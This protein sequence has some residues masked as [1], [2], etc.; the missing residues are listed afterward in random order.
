MAFPPP[1]LADET[2]LLAVGGD[3]SPRRLL[4]AYSLGIFPWYSE[5]LPI[6]WHS[7]DPR[8]VLEAD[9]I[10]L[11]R[12]L[13]KELRRGRYQV[14]LDTAFEEVIR[15]CAEMPRPGQSGTWITEEMIE[16]YLEM[17]E[18]GYAHSAE[19]WLGDRLVGG[20]YGVSLGAG[21]FGESMFARATDASKVAFASLV[22]QL[23]RWDIRLIDCQVHTEHMARFGAEEWPRDRF[24]RA[25]A[26]ALEQPTRRGR[27]R[28][29]EDLTGPDAEKRD[30]PFG[31]P[32]RKPPSKPTGG[33]CGGPR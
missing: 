24:L 19:A 33:S 6:L 21:F 7:P 4:L 17:H 10:A 3:L 25:L 13:R 15:A 20:L 1:Q 16:A 5:E 9:R 11:S 22:D 32:A 18:L 30:G 31:G 14:R 27:W 29:E 2:G 12:S 8:M 28:L 26:A 23:R